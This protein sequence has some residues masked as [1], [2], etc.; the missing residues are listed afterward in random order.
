MGAP[1]KDIQLFVSDRRRLSCGKR[2]VVFQGIG[3]TALPGDGRQRVQER[4][5]ESCEA[6]SLMHPGDEHASR[7]MSLFL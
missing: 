3:I 7:L 4:S 5:Q 2:G 1:L 6:E